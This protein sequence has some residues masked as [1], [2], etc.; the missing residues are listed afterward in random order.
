MRRW[1]V[2][3]GLIVGVGG[4]CRQRTA[5][6]LILITSRFVILLHLKA[7]QLPFRL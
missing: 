7:V 4:E 5:S 6:V 1:R 2:A 3:P